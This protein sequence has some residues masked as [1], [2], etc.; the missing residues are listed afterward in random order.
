VVRPALI[1]TDILSLFFRGQPN[2]VDSFEAYLVEH[3]K[4]NLSILTYYE[5]LSGLKHRDARKQIESFLD[6]ASYNNVLPLTQQS[7]TVSAD[8]YADLRVKG[9]PVDDIDILIAGIAIAN[10]LV[11]VTRNRKHF[12]RIDQLM[13]EDWAK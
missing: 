9:T 13:V 5:I 10:D 3:D 8:I 12:D 7:V 6:F 1:D 11:L 4:I 2:V